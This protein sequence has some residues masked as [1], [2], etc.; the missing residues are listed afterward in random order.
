MSCGIDRRHGLDPEL[1]WLWCRLTAAA[2]IQP[3]AWELPC[4]A[5]A[6][7]K[8]QKQKQK[9]REGRVMVG[10]KLFGLCFPCI[11]NDR[12]APKLLNTC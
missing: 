12:Y 9:I 3:L 10:E 6:A 5:G 1:L 7:L 2:L 4:A 11:C 8:K